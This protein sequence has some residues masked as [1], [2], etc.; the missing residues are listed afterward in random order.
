MSLTYSRRLGTTAHRPMGELRLA[1]AA[2]F[3][4]MPVLVEGR[5]LPAAWRGLAT[6]GTIPAMGGL[7]TATAERGYACA[8]NGS[9]RFAPTAVITGGFSA[10]PALTPRLEDSGS[11][12][13][14]GAASSRTSKS[15]LSL[16]ERVREPAEDGALDGRDHSTAQPDTNGVTRTTPHSGPSS[17]SGDP[18]RANRLTAV[19]QR[20]QSYDNPATHQ[21]PPNAPVRRTR[22]LRTTGDPHM[23][24]V[25]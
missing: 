23:R 14:W 16:D 6:S 7:S 21:H 25:C 5:T 13:T 19:F 8:A 10:E 9:I 20:D 12:G 22:P 3:G 2:W 11:N 1:P 4:P 17:I 24:A 18:A 15:P